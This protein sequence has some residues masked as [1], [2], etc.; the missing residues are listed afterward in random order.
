MWKN[1]SL[2]VWLVIIGLVMGGCQMGKGSE[3][4][5]KPLEMKAEDLPDVRALQDEF[6]R[7]FIESTEEVEPGYY[8]FLS[9]TK[10]YRMLFPKEGVIH[11][12]YGVKE[13]QFEGFLMST[14]NDNGT[15][16][17][18]KINYYAYATIESVEGGLEML[19]GSVGQKL[20]FEKVK[21][22]TSELY[23]A[24]FQF[25][26]D[27]FGI[28]A[29]VAS[30]KENGVI[31]IVYDT[32]CKKDQNECK[33]IKEEEVDKMIHWAESIEFVDKEIK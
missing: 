11:Q 6:T 20:E 21:A 29:L 9:G 18:I 8:S 27:T 1:Y 22:E 12:G 4:D 15:D 5:I 17:Q 32:Q 24:P 30:L 25:D 3:R 28:A 13:D 10:Q 33:Q 26:S 14:I 7:S 31:Q 23:Y 19:E 2:I 16:S